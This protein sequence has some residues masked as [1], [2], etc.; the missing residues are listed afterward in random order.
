LDTCVRRLGLV[1]QFFGSGSES[2]ASPAPGIGKVDR[3]LTTFGL[4]ASGYIASNAAKRSRRAGL[5]FDPPM[6]DAS[7]GR[8]SSTWP[9][10]FK[11]NSLSRARSSLLKAKEEVLEL[12]VERVDRPLHYQ[13]QQTYNLMGSAACLCRFQITSFKRW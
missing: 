13:A 12:L 7:R 2:R 3:L 4:G 6:K 8:S 9:C 11:S 10:V 5:W 1:W